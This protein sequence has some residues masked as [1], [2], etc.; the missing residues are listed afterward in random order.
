MMYDKEMQRFVN[1]PTTIS[2]NVRYLLGLK[3]GQTKAASVIITQTFTATN[4]PLS[5]LSA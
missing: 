2:V 4:K 3:H 5:G 1:S